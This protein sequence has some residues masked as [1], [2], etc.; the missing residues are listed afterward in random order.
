M[1][2]RVRAIC[3]FA[4]KKKNVKTLVS[5]TDTTLKLGK[6]QLVRR[7]EKYEEK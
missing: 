6:I 3:F 7:G 5:T 4:I 2:D 1:S